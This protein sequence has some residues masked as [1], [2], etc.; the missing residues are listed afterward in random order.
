MNEEL[1]KTIK[2]FYIKQQKLLDEMT[3]YSKTQLISIIEREMNENHYLRNEIGQLRTE[4][5]TKDNIINVQQK[6]IYK[7]IEA[8]DEILV[9]N[10]LTDT[11]SA[12]GNASRELKFYLS[13]CETL[14]EFDKLKELKE[15]K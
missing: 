13:E 11:T 7:T 1:N 8:I 6:R 2:E 10:D 14:E 15:N 12:F 3:N 9:Y 4:L 5:N